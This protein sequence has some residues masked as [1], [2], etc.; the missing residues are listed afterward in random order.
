MSRPT[1][2]DLSRVDLNL[3]VSFDALMAERSVTAAAV[4]LSVG[5]SAMSSTLARLR[6]LFDDPILV[7][8]GRAMIATPVAESL[9]EPMR[10]ALTHIQSLLSSRRRFDPSRDNKT[11]TVVASE[12]AALAV[13]HPLLVHLDAEAP[14]IR[15]RI[16]PI[17]VESR[18][19]LARHQIDLLIVPREAFPGFSDFRHEVLYRD[20]YK[21]AVDADHPDVGNSMSADQFSALPYLA[22]HYDL[23]P[24]LAEIQLDLL[25]V[26]RRVET[27]TGFMLAP[28]LL[29]NTRLITLVPESLGRRIGPAAHL[30]LLEPPMRLQPLTEMMIWTERFGDDPAHAWLRGRMRDLA[31]K[32]S[33]GSS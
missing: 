33:D 29:R 14:S 18:E 3:L 2:M 32:F 24:S 26:S 19:Q 10:E 15:L 5:Q 4:R 13:L 27:T 22:T 21:V 25:G 20:G 7:R 17:G 6:R 16:Q 11:F 12:Y 31:R 9:A 8:Q 28:F 23:Q 30:R 1:M